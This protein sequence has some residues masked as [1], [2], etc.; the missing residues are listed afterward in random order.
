VE[1]NK[2]SSQKTTFES[3]LKGLEDIADKLE[4]GELGL[5]VSI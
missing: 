4:S 1:K 5:D 2:K 3:A